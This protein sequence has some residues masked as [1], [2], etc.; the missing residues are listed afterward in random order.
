M[1]P[2][3][4][5]CRKAQSGLVRI[6]YD[7]SANAARQGTKSDGA[8]VLEND[9]ALEP[10]PPLMLEGIAG[11]PAGGTGQDRGGHN[12]WATAPRSFPPRFF[13]RASDGSPRTG[14][15]GYWSPGL[16]PC[17]LAKRIAAQT[18]VITALTF[19]YLPAG[20]LDEG[21][22]SPACEMSSDAHGNAVYPYSVG[23]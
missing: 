15:S 1:L 23:L 2:R 14:P 12:V 11:I 18:S 17:S 9:A 10:V 13:S 8:I 5:I 20:P 4:T 22:G 21:D 6:A 16:C 3:M 7:C 19:E